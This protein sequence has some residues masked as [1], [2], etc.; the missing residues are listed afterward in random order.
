MAKTVRLPP[1]FNF[2]EISPDGRSALGSYQEAGTSGVAVVPL[3][4]AGTVRL[5]PYT[6]T[7]R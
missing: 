7:S 1:G 4:G 6:Y 2:F 5:I 3:D